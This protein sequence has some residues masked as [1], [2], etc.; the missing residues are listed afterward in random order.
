[1]LFLYYNRKIW[2]YKYN[3]ILFGGIILNKNEFNNLSLGKQV[4]YINEQL[5]TKTLRKACSDIN[6][7]RSTINSR[8]K[9]NGYVFDIKK[10]KY[11]LKSKH[12]TNIIDNKYHTVQN[13]HNR[14]IIE[15]S[16]VLDRDKIKELIELLPKIKIL[17][18]KDNQNLYIE[19][20]KLSI[21]KE[22]FGGKLRNRTFILY[23]NI[24]DDYN[25]FC[26]NH[27][28]FKKQDIMSQALMEFINK[29]S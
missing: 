15:N 5:N 19:Q 25:E 3:S 1:M 9:T 8:F 21:D 6:I 12:N 28:E 20:S 7:A 27:R 13:K 11:I 14:N 17:L 26:D 18:E 2:Y 16:H 10:S 23:Q 22:K 4:E 29:Y 24:L